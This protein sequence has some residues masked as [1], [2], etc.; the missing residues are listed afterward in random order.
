MRMS[1]IAAA[2]GLLLT[3]L[4][5]ATSA[6]A[7]PYQGE[8]WHQGERG[9]HGERGRGERWHG[10]DHRRGYRGHVGWRRH[11]W[12]EWRHHHRVRVCR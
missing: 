11:C 3:S 4:G 6:D 8:R 5:M 12:I 10:G 1:H 9:H 7:Q 2:V